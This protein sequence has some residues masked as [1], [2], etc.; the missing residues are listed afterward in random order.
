M[1]QAMVAKRGLAHAV[2]MTGLLSC[3]SNPP[4]VRQ[5]P[6]TREKPVAFEESPELLS[7]QPVDYPSIAREAGVEGTVLIRALVGIDGRVK[8]MNV[9]QGVVGLNE[10]ALAAV[11]TA[12]FKPARK[13]GKPVAVWMTVPIEFSTGNH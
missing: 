7:M 13:D 10:A 8:Q 2:M 11:K 12:V 3:A 5:P 6:P 4:E 9:L 1:R